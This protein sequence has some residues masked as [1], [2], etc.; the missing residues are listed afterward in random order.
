M[1]CTLTAQD[2]GSDLVCNIFVAL[3]RKTEAVP[4]YFFWCE[5]KYVF[6]SLF[7]NVIV[8]NFCHNFANFFKF[9]LINFMGRHRNIRVDHFLLLLQMTYSVIFHR[10]VFHSLHQQMDWLAFNISYNISTKVKKN[11]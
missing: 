9:K 1:P 10:T 7:S 11:S 6:K 4:A 2:N 3:N 8:P 5:E